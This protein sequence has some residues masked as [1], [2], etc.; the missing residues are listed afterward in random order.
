MDLAFIYDLINY[1]NDNIPE[2]DDATGDDTIKLLSST[3]KVLQTLNSKDPGSLG[4]HPIVYFYSKKG[5]FKR[6]WRKKEKEGF[7]YCS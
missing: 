5:N 7:Y 2:V 6:D 3:R 4:L 1:C